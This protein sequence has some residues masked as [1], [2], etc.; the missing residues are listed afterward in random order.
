MDGLTPR[1]IWVA[2]IDA[3][4]LLN[5]EGRE[6]GEKETERQRQAETESS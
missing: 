2:Q 5:M 3:D 6:D 1:S 4:G